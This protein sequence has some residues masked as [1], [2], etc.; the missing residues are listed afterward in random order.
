MSVSSKLGALLFAR[1]V[2]L[3][4]TSQPVLA[5]LP[6]GCTCPAGFIPS[7]NTCASILPPLTFAAPICPGLGAAINQSIARIAA[8][9]QQTSFSGVLSVIETR[10]D[11]IQG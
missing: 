5:Q 6:T 4:W 8:T 11:Q 1:G 3:S 10:R 9:Q 2:A 7:G